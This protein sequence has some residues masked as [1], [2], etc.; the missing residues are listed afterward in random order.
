MEGTIREDLFSY[1]SAVQYISLNACL[2]KGELPESG[3]NVKEIK[4]ECGIRFNNN[5]VLMLFYQYIHRKPEN[6]DY[7]INSKYHL[8]G[9]R[10]DI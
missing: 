5:L 6:D 8:A 3:K 1:E 2:K 4:S 9:V 7:D 10:I